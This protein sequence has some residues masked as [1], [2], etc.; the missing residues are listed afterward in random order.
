M[1]IVFNCR[2]SIWTVAQDR[3]VICC[4]ISLIDPNITY[5]IPTLGDFVYCIA[6]CPIDTSQIAYGVGDA[7]IR[8]WNL[9][10]PN[11]NIIEPQLLWEKIKGKVRAV[12]FV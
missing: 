6:A 10:E 12:S 4:S 2:K 9:S 5:T 1:I 11:K 3:Q 7:M 8:L